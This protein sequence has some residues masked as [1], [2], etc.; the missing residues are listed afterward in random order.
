[1]L[2]ESPALVATR[3]PPA[4]REGAKIGIAALSGIVDPGLLRAG[5]RALWEMGF[6]PIEAENL[7]S[8]SAGMFAGTEAQRLGAFHRLA[9]DPEIAAIIF[10]RGGHGVLAL[11]PAI[12]WSLLARTPRSYVGYSDLTPLLDQVVRRL[13]LVALHGPMVAADVARGLQAAEQQ[14]FV[15]ALAGHFPAAWELGGGFGNQPVEGRLVGG[16]L[17]LLAATQGTPWAFAAGGAVLFLEEVGEPLYRLDRMLTH[18]RLSGTLG[19]IRGIVF[20]HLTAVAKAGQMSPSAAS[21]VGA[22]PPG[23]PLAWIAE[24]S[25]KLAIPV[26]WGLDAGHAAP[27]LTLPLGL[28]VRLDAAGRRLAVVTE[29]I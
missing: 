25:D 23:I 2:S 24:L 1:M 10:A 16:C 29:A 7:R 13:G 9:A 14:S 5:I 8:R 21:P 12:D 6:E 11:M 28:T 3:L 20:G 26:A 15:A 22:A 27:N 4:V 19:A 18:L 17:S